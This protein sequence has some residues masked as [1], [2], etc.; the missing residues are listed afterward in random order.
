MNILIIEDVEELQIVYK[1]FLREH[2]C[3]FC[4]SEKLMFNTLNKNTT[5]LIICDI[6]LPGQKDGLDLIKDLKSSNKFK[7]IPLICSSVHI[8]K[9]DL[10]L[11][12]GADFFLPK[13]F[14]KEIL[15]DTIKSLMQIKLD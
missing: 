2:N 12:I 4:S 15:L 5:D 8:D 10:A 11:E 1:N 7:K 9:K 13:P 6:G 14:R 3:F